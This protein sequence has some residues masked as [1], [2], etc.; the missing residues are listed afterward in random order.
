MSAICF[1]LVSFVLCKI[2]NCNS[3]R[4][5]VVNICGG[6]CEDGPTDQGFSFVSHS[7][8]ASLRLSAYFRFA[9]YVT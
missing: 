7:L 9:L 3:W 2:T 5:S 4:N 6:V 8:Q 1:E